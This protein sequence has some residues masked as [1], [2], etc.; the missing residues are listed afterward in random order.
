MHPR[1]EDLLTVRDGE[2]VDAATSRAI[3]DDARHS[4]DVER[5]R[6]VQNALCDLP[7]LE[8]PAGA[9]KRIV[10]A[11]HDSRPRG[12][13]WLKRAAGVGVAAAVAVAA[14]VYIGSASR[15]DVPADVAANLPPPHDITGT[16]SPIPPGATMP[17]G[18]RVVPASYGALVQE[19]ARL[20]GVLTRIPNQRSL[21]TGETA[22]TI[23]GLEDRIA[24]I[25]EQLTFSTARNVPQP[26][27]AALWSERVE[28]MN[29]LVHVRY[30]QAEPGF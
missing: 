21:M 3:A 27:R 9:W 20:D 22:A 23:A 15:P 4:N 2:P 19:S 16:T 12:G 29:A 25:D 30:A 7:E 5:L 10:E 24:V 17:L 13:A 14:V 6:R 26:Q 18:G 1:T 8:P 11:E 28:L